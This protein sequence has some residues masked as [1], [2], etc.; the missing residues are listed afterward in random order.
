VARLTSPD[1][2]DRHDSQLV[3]RERLQPADVIFHPRDVT[4]LPESPGDVIAA[5]EG[6][7]SVL[8]DEGDDGVVEVSRCSVPPQRDAVSSDGRHQ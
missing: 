8:D 7:G 5:V 3:P 2:V 6:G 1:T 4:D